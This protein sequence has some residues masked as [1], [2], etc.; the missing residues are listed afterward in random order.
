MS[1]WHPEKTVGHLLMI[2]CNKGFRWCDD[3]LSV[4]GWSEIFSASAALV[5]DE[6]GIGLENFMMRMEKL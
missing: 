6:L 2:I 1:F 3:D 5:G 4:K